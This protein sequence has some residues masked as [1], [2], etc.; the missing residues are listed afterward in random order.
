MTFL[1][2]SKCQRNRR[3]KGQRYCRECHN[4][5]QRAW[6]RARSAELHRLRRKVSHETSRAA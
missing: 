6:K 3:R 1:F 5:Y 4:D 2:C